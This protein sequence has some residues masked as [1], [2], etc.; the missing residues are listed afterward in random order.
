VYSKEKWH[1]LKLPRI[2]LIFFIET[3]NIV[4]TTLVSLLES[5]SGR[6]KDYMWECLELTEFLPR[7]LC[8]FLN[9]R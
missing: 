2:L 3:F 1:H 6:D 7:G 8:P 9:M 5:V 4:S